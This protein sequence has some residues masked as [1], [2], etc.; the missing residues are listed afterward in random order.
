MLSEATV[1]LHRKH[2]GLAAA[3]AA[4]VILFA[5]NTSRYAYW[6]LTSLTRRSG[7]DRSGHFRGVVAGFHS[8]WPRARQ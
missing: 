6:S 7:L 8:A 4:W 5:F 2:G 1:R 3:A